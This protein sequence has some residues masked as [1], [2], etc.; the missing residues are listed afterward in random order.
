M[1]DDS[2]LLDKYPELPEAEKS[3]LEEFMLRSFLLLLL[4]AESEPELAVLE[5]V[6]VFVVWELVELVDFLESCS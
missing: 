3:L 6:D 1:A 5:V 4:R 2:A